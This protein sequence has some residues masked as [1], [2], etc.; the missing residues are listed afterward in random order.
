[1]DTDGAPNAE[2]ET[3]LE[4]LMPIVRRGLE[5]DDHLDLMGLASATLAIVMHPAGEPADPVDGAA[6]TVIEHIVLRYVGHGT[7]EALAYAAAMTA[8]VPPG[9]LRSG[10]RGALDG[11]ESA[12]PAWLVDIDR[13]HLE[14]PT[15]VRDLFDD[16]EWLLVGIR[17][18]DGGTISLRISIDHDAN[19]RVVDAALMRQ[20]VDEVRRQLRAS[21]PE[22]VVSITDVTTPE[23]TE[24]F[25][26]A[27][28]V[29]TD[30]P[31]RTDTWP[32]SRP[33]VEWALSL[34][35]EPALGSGESP[36]T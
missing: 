26:D 29:D 7:R 13:S 30:D 22:D 10:L 28:A 15:V 25:A 1:M 2:D 35:S 31:A 8:L 16:D 20:T 18:L 5:S 19:G 27:I 21:A 9:P 6:D 32:S 12:L 34:G 36:V 17:F 24:R 23:L 11:V 4:E 3:S 33:L 14:Q